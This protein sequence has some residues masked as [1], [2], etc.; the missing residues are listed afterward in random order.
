[1]S[2]KLQVPQIEVTQS[3]TIKALRMAVV[4]PVAEKALEVGS[5][6]FENLKAGGFNVL[7]PTEN[8]RNSET[9]QAY[10]GTRTREQALDMFMQTDVVHVVISKDSVKDLGRVHKDDA[11]FPFIL[12][13]LADAKQL[14][15]NLSVVV[16]N[17]DGAEVP[18]ILQEY[19]QIDLSKPAEQSGW[20]LYTWQVAAN[21]VD[22]HGN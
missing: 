11:N 2:E 14:S 13:G 4:Y 19:A 21:L 22:P 8:A 10:I 6:F 17:V 20:L 1:M 5:N 7:D 15:G 3:E 12:L 18:P 9:L 16:V